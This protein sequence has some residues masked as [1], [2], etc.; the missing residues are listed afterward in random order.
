M[1]RHFK[2]G[3]TTISVLP[4]FQS[5][6]SMKSDQIIGGFEKPSGFEGSSVIPFRLS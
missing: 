1:S 4:Y 3:E 2:I 5:I 6:V